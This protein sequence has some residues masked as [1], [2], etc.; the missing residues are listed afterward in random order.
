MS[1]ERVFVDT[2]VVLSGVIHGGKP[3]VIL[4][5]ALEREIR[6]VL[7][8]AVIVETRNV[9]C[10]KFPD[11]EAQFEDFIRKVDYEPVPYPDEVEIGRVATLVRDKNDAPVLA[12]IL[13]SKPDVALTGDKDLLTDEVRAIVPTCRCAEYLERLA[14]D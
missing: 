8:E 4:R 3:G 6:L 11:E 7:A 1:V 9:L 14:E 12:S 10:E 5:L 13:A 2:N